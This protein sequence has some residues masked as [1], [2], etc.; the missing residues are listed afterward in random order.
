MVKK[1]RKSNFKIHIKLA[2]REIKQHVSMKDNYRR[3]FTNA[4]SYQYISE[5]ILIHSFTVA[6]KAGLWNECQSEYHRGKNLKENEIET[7]KQD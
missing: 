7:A 2:K 4:A 3:R 6:Q 1:R 5:Q